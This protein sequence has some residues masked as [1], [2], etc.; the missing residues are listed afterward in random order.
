MERRSKNEEA[1]GGV[2]EFGSLDD[3][4][5]APAGTSN[6][7]G[8]APT[9][10]ISPTGDE[11]D[12]ENEFGEPTEQIHRIEQL[13]AEAD[14]DFQP[15]GSIGPEVELHFDEAPIRSRKSLSTRKSSPTVTRRLGGRRWRSRR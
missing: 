9:L 15:A 4:P 14:D 11:L 12:C 2:I 10:R 7:E 6:A 8:T 1:A 5:D 13:L 3:A